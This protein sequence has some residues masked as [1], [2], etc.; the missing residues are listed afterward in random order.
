MAGSLELPKRPEPLAVTSLSLPEIQKILGLTMVVDKEF[1]SVMPMPV[2]QDLKF[3]LEKAD[4]VHSAHAAICA[5]EARIRYKL[6]LLL[7]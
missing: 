3:W 6:N 1:E 4:R 2:P 5:N 7:V